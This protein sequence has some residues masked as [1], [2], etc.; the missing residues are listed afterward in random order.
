[1]LDLAIPTTVRPVPTLRR[2]IGHGS[3]MAVWSASSCSRSRSS[4]VVRKDLYPSGASGRSAAVPAADKAVILARAGRRCE[5]HSPVCGR[6]RAAND[7][8]AD[9]VIPWSRSGPTNISDGQALCK[10]HNRAKGASVPFVRQ[11]RA[12]EKR[13]EHYRYPRTPTRFGGW[14]LIELK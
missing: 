4:K 8:Q 13:R 6:C 1:M 9:H 5:H 14:F 3:W 12:L 7:L 2:S 10:R 11:R